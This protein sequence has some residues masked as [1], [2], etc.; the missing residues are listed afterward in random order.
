VTEDIITQVQTDFIIGAV[1]TID[2]TLMKDFY[3]RWNMIGVAMKTGRV[4]EG[5]MHIDIKTE[6]NSLFVSRA[7]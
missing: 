3:R 4:E 1:M 5:I 2:Y 6:G 7:L